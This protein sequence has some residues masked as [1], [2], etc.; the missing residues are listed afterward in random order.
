MIP[1]HGYGEEVVQSAAEIDD[2]ARAAVG[3]GDEHTDADRDVFVREHRRLGAGDAGQSTD[4]AD[5][6]IRTISRRIGRSFPF[7]DRSAYRGAAVPKPSSA[8]GNTASRSAS[9]LTMS[10]LNR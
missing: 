9:D 8:S 10:R 4:G 1:V 6:T 3:A 5:T 7:V 2:R